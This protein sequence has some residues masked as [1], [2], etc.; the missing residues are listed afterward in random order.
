MKCRVEIL[1]NLECIRILFV[2][3]SFGVRACRFSKK[4]IGELREVQGKRNDAEYMGRSLLTQ[5]N[6]LCEICRS[7]LII[8]P[9]FQSY[10][11]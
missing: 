9:L 7:N 6:Y 2:G 11:C 1:W 4:R 8:F 5:T 10:L 3:R